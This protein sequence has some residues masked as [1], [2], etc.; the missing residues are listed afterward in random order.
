M[1]VKK[2]IEAE[3]APEGGESRNRHVRSISVK[4]SV[5]RA[6][7]LIALLRLPVLRVTAAE[8]TH[9]MTVLKYAPVIKKPA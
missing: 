5:L 1:R 6:V 7:F 8:E 9:A 3:H 2:T 4:S